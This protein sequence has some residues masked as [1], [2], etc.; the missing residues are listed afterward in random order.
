M[1]RLSFS[2]SK[3]QRE[4]TPQNRDYYCKSCDRCV[5]DFRGKTKQEADAII[6]KSKGKVCGIFDNDQVSNKR[7]VK[8]HSWFKFAFALVFIYGM[9]FNTI[10]QNP[11]SLSIKP[12]TTV[13]VQTDPVI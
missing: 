12:D 9:S 6:H 5:V 2:C 3:Y 4:L 11:D 8:V 1:A 7:Q 13:S 10:A